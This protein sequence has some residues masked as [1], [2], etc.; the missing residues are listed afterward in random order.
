MSFAGINYG[1]PAATGKY[2]GCFGGRMVF[3]TPV[4]PTGL[5]PSFNLFLL[6]RTPSPTWPFSHVL[7]LPLVPFRAINQ[8]TIIFNLVFI[9]IINIKSFFLV[10]DARG[11]RRAAEMTFQLSLCISY[12]QYRGKA[13]TPLL[14]HQS[15][16]ERLSG[17]G[18]LC[19]AAWQSPRLSLFST[20]LYPGRKKVPEGGNG[21]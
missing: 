1:S 19:R 9:P 12:I 15:H 3:P 4:F 20:A 17:V 6:P 11:Y 5:S 2:F 16:R 18:I 14:L 10:V 7:L 21:G 13:D 8:I